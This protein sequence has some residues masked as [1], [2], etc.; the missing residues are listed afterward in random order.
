M[1]YAVDWL[2]GSCI[3]VSINAVCRI[4]GLAPEFFLYWEE[5]DWCTRARRADLR[6]LVDPVASVVHLGWGSG[7]GRQT[8]RYAL[9]NSLLFVRRNLHG[10][11]GITS[12]LAW[13]L[14]RLPL[15]VIRRLKEGAGL[16]EASADARWAV[17]WHIRDISDHGWLRDPE[18]PTLCD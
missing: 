11:D 4:G 2:D 9:R 7:T 12:G 6:L 18:G 13:L 14:G 5:T 10:A 17:G 8:R 1:P 15:F 3:L 16:R